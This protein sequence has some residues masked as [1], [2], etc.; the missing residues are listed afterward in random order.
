[1]T[2]EWVFAAVLAG[3][4]AFLTLAFHRPG[5]RPIRTRGA[6]GAIRWDAPARR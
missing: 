4:F 2:I 6:S 5:G 1:M 3:A